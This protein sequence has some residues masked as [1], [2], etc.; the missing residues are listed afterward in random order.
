MCFGNSPVAAAPAPVAPPPP[1][2]ATNV[3]PP[4][5]ASQVN[6]QQAQADLKRRGT[7]VFRNDIGLGIPTGG[8]RPGNGVNIPS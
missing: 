7:Q 3:K 4:V 8:A 1:P 6:Q 5:L 2:P